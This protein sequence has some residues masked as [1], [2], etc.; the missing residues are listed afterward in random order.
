MVRIKGFKIKE[1]E[2]D[3]VIL[4]LEQKINALEKNILDLEKSKIGKES[5]AQKDIDEN[6]AKIKLEITDIK[7][8]ITGR[9]ELNQ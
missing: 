4:S 3:P 9:K 8:D 5:D 7:D 2:K 1:S 6:I